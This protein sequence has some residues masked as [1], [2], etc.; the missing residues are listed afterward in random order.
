MSSADSVSDKQELLS[1]IA[2]DD[3]EQMSIILQR[4]PSCVIESVGSALHVAAMYGSIACTEHLL[5]E[6]CELN[7][8]DKDG[9]TP[10][11]YAAVEGDP[12]I[13]QMLISA[14]ADLYSTTR[15]TRA[16]LM[17]GGLVIDMAG[18]RNS[19]HLAAENGNSE[20][21]EVLYRA[22]PQLAELEDLDGA[23]PRDVAL[24]EGARAATIS[25]GRKAVVDLL[26]AEPIPSQEE[27]RAQA[28]ADVAKGRKRL[29]L[30]EAAQK[31]R[32]A[33]EKALNGTPAD[34]GYQSRWP[35]LYG[36]Q[37]SDLH[38]LLHPDLVAALSLKADA[39]R[40]AVFK[41]CEEITPGVYAFQ[42]IS[43]GTAALNQQLL[44]ELD[45]IESWAAESPWQLSRPNSMNRYG[46]VLQDVGL[47]AIA[48]S[49]T[50]A[51]VLPLA[52]ALWPGRFSDLSDI[53]AFTV[54]YREN[55][56]RLLDTH[57]DSSDVTLNL[58]LGGSFEGG[59]VYFHG[60]AGEGRDPMTS[61][62]PGGPGPCSHCRASHQHHSGTALIH[63][64]NHI[65][66]AHQL[67]K[68][69]RTN[70]ILWCRAGQKEAALPELD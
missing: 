25:A 29:D 10:L 13:L 60:P 38:S 27:L 52:A 68:G 39:R 55:E 61:P 21:A 51:V 63:L 37:G 16:R 49:L 5:Q 54:R 66:G 35:K 57:V 14:R 8:E 32:L 2:N 20:A 36:L 70:L 3:A 50:T 7:C 31:V 65:H 22:C 4:S 42:C 48:Q 17:S 15:D 47:G 24:R 1:A 67:R 28:Q 34:H 41:I 69:R 59:D 58:C 11:H 6:S 45:N 23:R 33:E 64:G 9:H 40:E 56:D 26:G 53:H 30:A 18:G 62:H 44:E 19:L 43:D 46:V 12:E